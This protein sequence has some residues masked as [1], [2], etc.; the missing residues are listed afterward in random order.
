[1]KRLLVTG[2]SGLVGGHII[3]QARGKWEVHGTFYRNGVC[4][5]HAMMHRVSLSDESSARSLI[6]SVRP[7][8][9]IHTAAW[10]DVDGC[11]KK[12]EL[13]RQI[14]FIST[15]WIAQEAA[16]LSARL[17]YL[18]S[19]MVFD[20]LKGAYRE[21]D[22]P[23][24]VNIY[25]RT[26]KEGEDAVLGYHPSAVVA[27]VALVYGQPVHQG[28]SFSGRILEKARQG[29]S[30]SLYTDQYRS[31]VWVNNLAE[32]LLELAVLPFGGIIH[33]G[34]PDRINRF[35]FGQYLIRKAGCSEDLLIPVSMFD[36]APFA[37][38]PQDAS[39]NIRKAQDLL[40]TRLTGYRESIDLMFPVM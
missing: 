12:P 11:E 16:A 40:K 3:R 33:L 20:G 21:N 31:P 37:S 38:R 5:D 22:A 9:I 19:D 23:C 27:R 26:K 28:N 36:A 1:M 34:G 15:E 2:G 29:E 10:T 8:V 25:G 39:F 32:A 17:I 35:I 30:V 7:H 13:A 6:Q 24:P 18:S 4:F 14:N